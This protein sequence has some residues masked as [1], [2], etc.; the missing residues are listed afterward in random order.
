MTQT[1]GDFIKEIEIDRTTGGEYG[2]VC[3]LLQR[4][5]LTD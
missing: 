2:Y 3:L 4:N 1:A 5:D